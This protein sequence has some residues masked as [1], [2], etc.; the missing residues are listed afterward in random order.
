VLAS[1]CTEAKCL[2]DAVLRSERGSAVCTV[3]G[4]VVTLKGLLGP[5]TY[6]AVACVAAVYVDYWIGVEECPTESVDLLSDPANCGTCGHTCAPRQICRNGHCHEPTDPIPP[7][8]DCGGQDG[9]CC[10]EPDE[11]CCLSDDNVNFVCCP[12]SACSCV[13][14]LPPGGITCADGRADCGPGVCCDAAQFCCEVDRE[15]QLL[16]FCVER[17][18]LCQ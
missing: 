11:F 6:V 12:D 8:L 1:D 4:A 18:G 9:T 16:Q 2:A 3:G 13:K 17:G 5:I 15:G 10:H 7:C 14:P